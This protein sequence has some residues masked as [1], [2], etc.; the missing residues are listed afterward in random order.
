MENELDHYLS[1]LTDL[2][3]P[4][5]YAILFIILLFII[6]HITY[7]QVFMPNK[8][9][10]ELEKRELEI[11]NRELEFERNRLEIDNLR[12]IAEFTDSD[13]N[14]IIRTNTS[15][16]IIHFNKSAGIS[17]V[18][19]EFNNPS[20]TSVLKDIVFD[21]KKEIENNSNIILNRIIGD[22]HFTISF[23]GISSLEMAQIYFIDQT[24][25]NIYEQRI[26]ASE[27]KFRSLSF[28]L[29]DELESEKQR[30]GMDLH[31]SIGQNLSLVKMKL[32]DASS[33]YNKYISHYEE[34]NSSLDQTILD[35]REIMM[36]LKPRTLEDLGLFAAVRALVENMS[37]KFELIGS[38][39]F[40]GTPKRPGK[41]AELYLFRIIQESLNNILKH[42]RAKEFHVQFIFA[43][44]FMK[45]SISDNGIGF[46]TDNILH[47]KGYGLLNMSER[48]KNLP[49]LN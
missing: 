44:K 46:D 39:D 4:V 19:S 25:R 27:Q 33:D 8:K 10:H 48:I 21:L 2:N 17:F 13:P 6:V 45:I 34:I 3:N 26:I 5:Y 42:S 16:E 29:Q 1:L 43:D 18:L 7:R 36:N 37:A 41:K 28:Y 23:Y 15:G 30:I 24:E 40:S 32:N 22:R 14:P 9:K 47:F 11:K 12:I 49:Y 31:D 20:I 35:L 38:I